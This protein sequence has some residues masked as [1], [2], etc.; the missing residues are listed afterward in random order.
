MTSEK[1]KDGREGVESR[2]GFLLHYLYGKFRRGSIR[3]V[4]FK[5]LIKLERGGYYSVTLRRIFR[6]YYQIDIGMY[7]YGCFNP[8]A[9]DAFTS[10][11]RYCSFAEGVGIFNANHPLTR[12]STHPFF[13]E[14]ALGYV[15]K[16]MIHRRYIEVGHDVWVGRN[17]LI[18]PSVKR[19]GNGAVIGAGSVVTKDVPDFAVVAGN[20]ARI[21]RY[22]FSEAV[23]RDITHSKWWEKSIEELTSDIGKFINDFSDKGITAGPGV[24]PDP[25]KIINK[26][27]EPC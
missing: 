23:Q 3:R 16:E 10:I 26:E 13:Y 12:R 2:I 18:T 5:L 27:S 1:I 21:L 14:P 8:D 6:D 25:R 4:I 9:I 19:I 20:P 22:R 15:P 17:A 11:G 24:S 7:S